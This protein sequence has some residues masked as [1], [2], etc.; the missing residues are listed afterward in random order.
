MCHVS[1]PSSRGG[2]KS[3]LQLQDTPLRSWLTDKGSLTRKI[4]NCCNQFRVTI[5]SQALAYPFTDESAVFGLR[6]RRLAWVREVSLYA[7]GCP[8]VYARSVLSQESMRGAWQVL[9]KIGNKPIGAVLFSDPGIRRSQL[10]YKKLDA[11]HSLR[12]ILV[13]NETLWAR[14]SV[15]IRDKMP[16]L[17]NEVF[18]PEILR[19]A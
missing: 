17:V 16:L 14:R 15:F 1:W 2:W 5:I 19:L 8:V 11:Q 12:H 6:N 3:H 9:S 10:V 13:R 7:D 18:M 4:Q